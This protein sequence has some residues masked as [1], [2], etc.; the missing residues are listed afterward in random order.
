MS[1]ADLRV[2][3]A[4]DG[5][6]EVVDPGFDTL[7]L[8]QAIDPSFRVR[9]APLPGFGTPRLLRARRTGTGVARA[10][11]AAA[12]TADLWAAHDR[13][14][15]TLHQGNGLPCADGE[16]H[17]LDAKVALADRLLTDCVLCAH[18]C[19]VDRTRGERGVC[20]L[21]PDALVAEHFVH[22]GEE[23]PIN[24]SLVLNL[25]G[26][27]L[28]C[29]GCQQHAILDPARAAGRPLDAALWDDLGLAGARSLSF[30]GGNPD[31]SLPAALRFLAAAPPGWPLPVVWNSHA[32]A[33]PEALALLDGVV[34]AYVPD[35]KHVSEPCARRYARVAG[36]PAVAHRSI[37]RMLGQGVPVYV[38]LLLLPGHAECCHLPALD[39]LAE[40][41][42]RT[43]SGLLHVSIR[44]QYAPDGTV[45]ERDGP[46]ARRTTVE[47]TLPVWDRAR[48]LGLQLTE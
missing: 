43:A 32:Y 25:A 17:L 10:D 41:D 26:C 20:R 15:D 27:G 29:R 35:F 12:G 7:D 40:L 36:Y 28:R 18:R 42:D 34:D 13:A 8:L 16:A 44:D 47:E 6:L 2:R 3:V 1:R 30:V 31:E 46:L 21:G 11:L 39:R 24:P 37:E 45:T 22:I 48:R 14:L 33:T 4:D 9:S 38:R 5:R 19:G 23:P